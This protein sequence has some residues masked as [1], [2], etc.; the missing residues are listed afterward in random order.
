MPFIEKCPWHTGG[1]QNK[2]MRAVVQRVTKSR[3]TV[4]TEVTGEINHGLMVL[5]GVEDGDTEKDA[6]Y[7]ADKVSGLRIFEDDN[8]KMNLSVKDIGG[9]VLAVSQFTLL[10]DARKG[11]RPSFTKAASPE[12]ADKLYRK[13]IEFIT[14]NDIHVEE[15]VFQT[16]MTVDIQN[17]GPVTIL[18]DSRKM[19]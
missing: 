15:G 8:E 14:G 6:E 10:G 16:H 1:I 9:E 13:V 3:V 2:N 11:K 18:L 17:D 12:E 5:I 19:F 7:I 4:E